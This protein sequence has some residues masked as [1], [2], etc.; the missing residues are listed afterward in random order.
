MGIGFSV[1][2]VEDLPRES[3]DVVLDAVVTE[4]ERIW[5]LLKAG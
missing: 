5:N 2:L 3:H 4:S 1:Q